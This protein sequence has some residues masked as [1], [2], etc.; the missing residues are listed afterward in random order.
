MVCSLP[1][2]GWH[3]GSARRLRS[4][5][6]PVGAGCRLRRPARDRRESPRMPVD[7]PKRFTRAWI[8]R[9]VPTLSRLEADV[10]IAAMREGMDRGRAA[11]ARL[12]RGLRGGVE[13][14]VQLRRRIGQGRGPAQVLHAQGNRVGAVDS[15]RSPDLRLCV[16][17]GWRSQ[18]AVS[19]VELRRAGALSPVVLRQRKRQP[20]CTQAWETSSMSKPSIAMPPASRSSARLSHHPDC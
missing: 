10:V 9:N 3:E 17:A 12:Q 11:V 16:P 15:Q 6:I 4:G 18:A 1:C 8:E 20:C 19:G 13:G 7:L 14:R 2:V 5:C